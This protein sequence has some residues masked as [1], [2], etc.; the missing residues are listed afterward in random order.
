MTWGNLSSTVDSYSHFLNK[1]VCLKITLERQCCTSLH[2][3]SFNS[4]YFPNAFPPQHVGQKMSLFT[5]QLTLPYCNC[6]STVP[7]SLE[8]MYFLK[9]IFYL[10]YW[11]YLK[12]WGQERLLICIIQI[13][14]VCICIVPMYVNL[15]TY[16]CLIFINHIQVN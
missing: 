10:G 2:W 13:H 8:L 15:L 3:R 7:A 16:F 14:V 5:A 4:S 12:C 11:H 1:S 6:V 9:E